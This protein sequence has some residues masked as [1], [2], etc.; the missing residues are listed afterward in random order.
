MAPDQRSGMK[1]AAPHP[2]HDAIAGAACA[3]LATMRLHHEDPSPVRDGCRFPYSAVVMAGL[4]PVR[5]V[6]RARCSVQRCFADP[7][8]FQTRS[9]GWPRISS[10]PLTRCAASGAE[11]LDSRLRR[12]DVW[13]DHKRDASP[14]HEERRS[15]TRS[16]GR[17]R[18]RGVPGSCSRNSCDTP[19][20]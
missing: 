2:G 12:D 5:S 7:G 4:V 14:H 18:S 10:A 13:K 15:I 16:P 19:G 6:S 11:K 8:P 17:R 9:V 3:N 1:N 20:R